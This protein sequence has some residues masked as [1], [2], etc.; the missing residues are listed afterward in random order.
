MNFRETLVK[1]NN[2]KLDLIEG[3]KRRALNFKILEKKVA[4]AT[5]LKPPTK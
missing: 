2:P 1:P 5:I 3:N 4:V